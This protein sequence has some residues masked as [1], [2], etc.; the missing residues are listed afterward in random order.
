MQEEQKQLIHNQEN[1]VKEQLELQKELRLFKESRFQEVLDNPEGS[2]TL[3]SSQCRD[4]V[5]VVR[6]REMALGT[7]GKGAAQKGPP[8]RPVQPGVRTRQCT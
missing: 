1:V 5:I 8:G 3:K 2:K 4:K 6:G 7:A